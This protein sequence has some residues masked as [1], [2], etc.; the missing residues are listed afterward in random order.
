MP[1]PVK[2]EPMSPPPP[3]DD[4]VVSMLPIF[5]DGV[6]ILEP[7][8][9]PPRSRDSSPARGGWAQPS[10]P[11]G[12]AASI[13]TKTPADFTAESLAEMFK[14]ADSPFGPGMQKIYREA[15]LRSTE[16]Q[17]TLESQMDAAVTKKE[18]QEV[19]AKKPQ[20]EI[21]FLLQVLDTIVD[22]ATGTICQAG[23]WDM[24]MA[25]LKDRAATRNERCDDWK[26]AWI[27][28]NLKVYTALAENTASKQQ[29][30][31]VSKKL[32]VP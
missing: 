6:E 12:G 18:K 25:L 11:R 24:Q 4:C 30:G 3:A 32:P 23:V 19:L 8:T 14:R 16:Q 1:P 9:T 5:V 22:P 10:P 29:K 17:E 26:K 28:K 20:D 27:D 21:H 7:D 31:S 2:E 13:R 15:Q